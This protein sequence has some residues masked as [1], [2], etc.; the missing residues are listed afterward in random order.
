[1]G[2]AKNYIKNI[3]KRVYLHEEASAECSADVDVVISAGELCAPAWQIKSVH[4]PGQ[5]LPNVVS[6]HQ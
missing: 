6:R 3:T 1:M 2:S 5:L 4:D